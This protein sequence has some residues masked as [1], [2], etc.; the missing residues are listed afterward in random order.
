[1]KKICPL[2]PIDTSFVE[3]LQTIEGLRQEMVE[4][5]SIPYAFFEGV[6]S[7]M[8]TATEVEMLVGSQLKEL[9][10]RLIDNA[11]LLKQ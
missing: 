10:N 7:K 4:A 3:H 2:P 1:M 6:P 5:C 8:K 11:K 9:R